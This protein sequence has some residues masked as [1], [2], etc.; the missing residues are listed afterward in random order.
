MQRVYPNRHMDG[1]PSPELLNT[2]F[3]FN[4]RLVHEHLWGQ[5]FDSVHVPAPLVFGVGA[6]QGDF[7]PPRHQY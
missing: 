7:A 3:L 4:R 2:E 1:G 5:T 6:V